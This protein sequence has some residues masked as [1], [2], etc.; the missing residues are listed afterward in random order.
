MASPASIGNHPIHP[1][2]VALPI[3]LWV[4]SFVCDLIRVTGI[5]SAVWWDVAY[6]TMAGGLVAALV[7]AVPGVV[8]MFAIS[9]PKVGRIAWNHMVLNLV[10]IALFAVN[11]YWRTG[12]APG[13]V[14][15]VLLSLAGVLVLGLS[16]W[17]GGEMV[18]VHGVGIRERS[19]A[20]ELKPIRPDKVR[21]LGG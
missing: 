11:L 6:L 14:F 1:M 5:G 7:A 10:V 12:A 18:Y 16:G 9:D 21:R 13:G 15:P 20:A 17:L 4:F 3:G 19:R 8:D 2:L